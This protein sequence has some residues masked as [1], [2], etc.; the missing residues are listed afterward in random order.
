MYQVLLSR[1]KFFSKVL[2]VESLHAFGVGM[3]VFH[4]LPD[5]P[6]ETGAMISNALC[7]VPSVLSIFSRKAAKMTLILIIF[8]VA[9]AA[10]Q[11][12]GFWAWP[13]SFLSCLFAS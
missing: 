10:S 2:L 5:I 9:A 4:V 1:T 8:D 3:L 6:A 7:M 11:S 13:V 12:S